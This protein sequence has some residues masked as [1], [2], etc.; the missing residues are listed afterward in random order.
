VNPFD[1]WNVRCSTCRRSICSRRAAAERSLTEMEHQELNI[2][3]IRFR[4]ETRTPNCDVTKMLDG[5]QESAETT[6]RNQQS[7]I[8]N[9][10]F[11]FCFRFVY[12]AYASASFAIGM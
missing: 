9:H 3:D 7:T 8:N 1:H 6:H 2:E 11:H 5:Q 4:Q 10:Q 12:D